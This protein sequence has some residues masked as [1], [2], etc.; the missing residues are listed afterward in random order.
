MLSTRS[1]LMSINGVVRV[2]CFL[3]SRK[4]NTPIQTLSWE[5]WRHVSNTD[6]VPWF[7]AENFFMPTQKLV[8]TQNFM[9]GIAD[10]LSYWVT[11]CT[12]PHVVRGTVP[13]Y[14]RS[15]TSS[16]ILEDRPPVKAGHNNTI[17]AP[18]NRRT[19]PC[20]LPLYFKSIVWPHEF[21]PHNDCAP[22]KRVK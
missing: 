15:Q 6:I 8:P 4:K 13:L 11:M 14:V 3:P 7:Q 17:S 19:I 1:T 21:K 2:C 12:T 22:K 10:K 9:S 16:L 5:C 20:C 18:S